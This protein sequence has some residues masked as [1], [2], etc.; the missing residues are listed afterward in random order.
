MCILIN[1]CI[2]VLNWGD[3]AA[4]SGLA[5][6]ADIFGILPEGGEVAV[7]TQWVETTQAP[8]PA[9]DSPS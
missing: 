6:S 8:D 7:G 5:M 9:E 1:P 4:R 2:I 3:S